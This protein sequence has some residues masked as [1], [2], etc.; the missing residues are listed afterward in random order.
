M[1]TRGPSWECAD[2]FRSDYSLH[3][4]AYITISPSIS[5][6]AIASI[7]TS[8]LPS[9]ASLP[10]SGTITRL[11]I[12]PTHSLITHP[13]SEFLLSIFTFSISTSISF[14][15]VHIYI[16]ISLSLSISL[17]LSLPLSISLARP[18]SFSLSLSF[19]LFLSLSL[20]PSIS[21]S[22]ALSL[23]LPLPLFLSLS[24]CNLTMP[25]SL[26][27]GSM[28]E[29]EQLCQRLG[30][31]VNGRFRC[32][33]SPSHLRDKF[34]QGYTGTVKVRQVVQ[35]PR[36]IYQHNIITKLYTSR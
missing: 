7:R 31:L 24:L 32:L 29:C 3:I 12:R 19:S 27:V 11:V 4:G 20:Y 8:Y 33:G 10:L 6:V 28:N 17:Y 36:T 5:S 16:H 23:L 21:L 35:S 26:P 25:S 14:R 18:L 2:L 15:C 13:P 9:T 22:L 1:R 30:I 34:G